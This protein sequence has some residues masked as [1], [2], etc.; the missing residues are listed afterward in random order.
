MTSALGTYLGRVSENYRLYVQKQAANRA[1]RQL[2][3]SPLRH[4]LDELLDVV[5]QCER[6]WSIEE[7][8]EKSR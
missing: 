8:I 6:I 1:T 5:R 3:L 4:Q 2:E 7:R